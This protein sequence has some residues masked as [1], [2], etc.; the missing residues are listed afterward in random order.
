MEKNLRV[1]LMKYIQNLHKD[2][3]DEWYSLHEADKLIYNAA[4][5]VEFF[6]REVL[7]QYQDEKAAQEFK[8]VW[9]HLLGTI[10]IKDNDPRKY[11]TSRD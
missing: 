10:E 5:V 8:S 6:R 9:H 4:D 3:G 11:Q 1:R 2:D 7:N